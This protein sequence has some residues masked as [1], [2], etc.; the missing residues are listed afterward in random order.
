MLASRDPMPPVAALFPPQAERVQWDDYLTRELLCANDR[1]AR[2]S[3][4]PTIDM[5]EFRAQLA[6]FDFQTPRGLDDLLPWTIAQLE[7][8]VVHVTSPRYFGLFNPGPSFPALCGDRL[9]GVFNPQ[10]ATA[11][12]SPVAVEMESH[13]IRAI[14]RRVGLP[15]GSNGHFTSGGSEANYTAVL[16]ALTHANERFATE[17]ARAFSGPP[18]FYIS[19]E[20]HLAWVKIGHQAGIGRSAV[21]Q[22]PTD[23]TGRMDADALA[24]MIEED[25][26][27]GAVPVSIVATAGTTNAG[28]IDP[29]HRC[30]D[31]ARDHKLWLHVDAAWGGAVVASERLRGVLSGI[32]RA[33]S[34]TIDAHKWFATT[35]GCGM[36][37]TR[38]P[39]ILSRTFQVS[40]GFMPS[41]TAMVDP[42]VTTAQWSRRFLG[43]RL[44]LSLAAAGWSG[45]AQHVE[46]AADLIAM[47]AALLKER[48]WKIANDSPL[49]LLCVEP[50]PDAAE[51]RTV[52]KRVLASG[53]AWIAVAKY[54][55]RDVIRIC[56]THGEATADDVR[57][58]VEA[59]TDAC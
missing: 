1:V 36:F 54:E 48:G 30:A 46:R 19:R 22:V 23:G 28:M 24:K 40:T 59:L 47:L 57:E 33:D 13:V 18:V 31:L 49:A 32:E 20:S 21:R 25:K 52:G 26:A 17:G 53:R 38:D 35:M 42:Y 55:G 44:F 50:P 43:V 15:A 10:L 56:L 6:A 5:A 14:A 11:T 34:V 39:E 12:T 51:I 37:V 7:H 3:V 29:I 2:G 4:V 8:G 45:Y 27:R 16:C 58:L 41:N 9:T